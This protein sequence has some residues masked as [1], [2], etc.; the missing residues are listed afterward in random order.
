MVILLLQASKWDPYLLSIIN[1]SG[2]AK[3]NI[4]LPCH[5]S[6][7]TEI[8]LKYN[9]NIFLNASGNIHRDLSVLLNQK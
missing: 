1:R 8:A 6:G 4:L 5:F 2:E 9:S 7:A 3:R